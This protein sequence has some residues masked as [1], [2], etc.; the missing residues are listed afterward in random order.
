MASKISWTEETVNVMSGCTKCSPG[1]ANCYA[2][3][4]ACRLQRM[5]PHKYP[6]GF[7]VTLH[8]EELEK[9]RRMRKPKLIFL[10]S[11][12]DLFHE[13]VPDAY[14]REVFATMA[15]T[16]HIYQVLTKRPERMAKFA[17]TICWP[18]NVWAGTT[19]EDNDH[20]YR[21]DVL[22]EIQAPVRFIS[23]EPLLGPLPDLN[24]EGI[25]WLIAG[26]ESGTGWRP[27]EADWVRNLRDRCFDENVAFF[28]KQWAGF[29]PAKL[30]DELDG[31]VWDMLPW[32]LEPEVRT[33]EEIQAAEDE[34]CD[35]V[36]YD[37]HQL[38]KD[39]D[40]EGRASPSAESM[41]RAE[42]A[43]RRI[44]EKFG[45]ENVGPYDDFEWGELNGKLS[46]LRWVLGDDW[47]MLDT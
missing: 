13:D 22:R 40:L 8:P 33:R 47:D 1:C 24:L 15:L 32:D 6:N 16:P 7:A 2:E 29:Q 41:A 5:H 12:G 4:M 3:R 43:A 39:R 46:A 23:A 38:L 21:A 44:E 37:R 11:M 25:Q 31:V 30:G 19:I 45:I 10:C 20:V 34:M 26:G 28:F 14:I 27:M 17:K 36:W 42:E 18:G 9:L 35:K